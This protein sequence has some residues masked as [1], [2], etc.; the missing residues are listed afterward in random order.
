MVGLVDGRSLQQFGYA[1]DVKATLY[2]S[3]PRPDGLSVIKDCAIS[4]LA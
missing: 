1:A 3:F 2:A 4:L